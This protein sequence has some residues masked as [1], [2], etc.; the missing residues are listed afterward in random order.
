MSGSGVVA[1]TSGP[2]AVAVA[3]AVAFAVAVP[4]VHDIHTKTLVTHSMHA[5][6]LA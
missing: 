5:R 3:V 6:G 4:L 1:S 2:C